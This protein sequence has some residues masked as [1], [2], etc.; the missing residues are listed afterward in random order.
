MPL[1]FHH[2]VTEGSYY[3][4]RHGTLLENATIFGNNLRN[5]R[6]FN[7]EIECH[8]DHDDRDQSCRLQLQKSIKSL[9][10]RSS[11]ESM[12]GVYLCLTHCDKGRD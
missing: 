10:S 12:I 11:K 5:I 2:F 4:A 6:L 9:I 8:K 3:G 1:V 7:L